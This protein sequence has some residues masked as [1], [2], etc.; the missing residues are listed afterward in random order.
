MVQIVCAKSINGQGIGKCSVLEEGI[1][2][3]QEKSLISNRRKFKPKLNTALRL[4]KSI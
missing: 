2:P 3:I 4:T 1:K